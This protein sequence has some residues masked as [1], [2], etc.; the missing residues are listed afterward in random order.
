MQI[1]ATARVYSTPLEISKI[2]RLIPKIVD[3]NV[4]QLDLSHTV[5]GNVIWCNHFG[6]SL[7]GNFLKS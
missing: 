3:K 5:V 4:E 2:Q 6:N 7:L 1:K